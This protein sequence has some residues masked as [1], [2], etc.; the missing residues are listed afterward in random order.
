MK[1]NSITTK[2]V[3]LAATFALVFST[4]F[5]F[6]PVTASSY[7][8]AD[9]ATETASSASSSDASSSAEESTDTS[10]ESA[11]S[12]E[13]S[14]DSTSAD[15]DSASSS[16]DKK[17][18]KST[19]KKNKSNKSKKSTKTKTSEATENAW[20]AT[21]TSYLE[22][23][24]TQLETATEDLHQITQKRKVLEK[25]AKKTKKS[26]K[27]TKK[28]LASAR[29]SFNAAA[30]EIYK[31]GSVSYMSVLLGA[32]DFSDFSSKLYLL[33]AMAYDRGKTIQ[34]VT[35][36]EQELN[37]KQSSYD[38]QLEEIKSLETQARNNKDTISK[39]ISAQLSFDGSVDSKLLKKIL[40]ANSVK[41]ANKL[42]A[43]YG[44]S[45]SKKGSHPEIVKIAAKY[46]GVPYVWGGETPAGFDCSGLTMYCYAKIGISLP[47]FARDQYFCGK[48]IARDALM[49]GDLVFFGP[50]VAGIHHVGIYV[51]DGKYIQAPHTGDVV[52]VSSLSDRSDYVGA[53]RPE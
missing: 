7:A 46:L 48:H 20:I 33:E 52:K 13:K 28:E 22:R 3:S 35:A 12:S 47:H 2:I 21:A 53:C 49:P 10:S 38:K 19:S 6:V 1:K 11:A 29:K 39:T 30:V 4:T 41:G 45:K 14:A 42:L 15:D 32:N 9:T 5:A 16:K 51:G 43:K 27:Q 18:S 44:G 34:D 8:L 40:N 37:E 31:N 50:C 25:K 17:T 23:L 24:A 36:L 26:I